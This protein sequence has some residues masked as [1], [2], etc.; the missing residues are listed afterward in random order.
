VF[1]AVLGTTIGRTVTMHVRAT[2]L[3]FE[4]VA[5]PSVGTWAYWSA[6]QGRTLLMGNRT[7]QTDRRAV[8]CTAETAVT[9]V[10]FASLVALLPTP[11][12]AQAPEPDTR[13]GL[14]AQAQAQ[15]STELHPYVPTKAE[16]YIDYAENILTTG[17]K[18]HPFFQSAYS[19]GGFTVGAGYRTYVGPYSSVDVRGSITPSGYKRIEGE[20]VAPR[21]FERRGVLSVIGGWR[22]ATQ[23]GFYGLGTATAPEQRA[24]YGFKQPYGTATL[25]VRPTRRVLLLRAGVEASQWEQTP[26]AGSEPSVE[27]IYTPATL[28]GLGAKVTYLHSQATIGV[29]SRPGAG[30]ARRGGF[31]G[32]TFHDFTD[33][34][35]LYGFKQIDYEALQH[36]PILREAWV[37]SFRGAVSTTGVKSG[38][39]IPFFMLPSVGGGS[40][41]R[42]YSSWRFRDRNSLEVQAEW[43]VMVNRYIDTAVFYDTGKV[44]ARTSDLNFDDLKHDYG[45]GIRFHG[46]LTTPVRVDFAQGSEG[47]HIVFA[48]S[49]V[50]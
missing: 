4:T 34:D 29:D 40:S 1:G 7:R 39:Q 11:V 27:E 25:T 44:T 5:A 50:F 19:G 47:F 38:E 32:V 41:L 33:P 23:V 15:K 30:Y 42:A 46:P 21:L 24:N 26:G 22:E 48:A 20:F 14:V 3:A 43:R 6:R 2:Q 28:T 16:Q 17:L 10:L 13:A 9:I 36:V 37:L 45:F 49:A 8:G 35:N 12:R 18:F 31:L